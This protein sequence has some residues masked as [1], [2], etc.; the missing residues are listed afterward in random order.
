MGTLSL[1]PLFSDYVVFQRDKPIRIWGRSDAPITVNIGGH[2]ATVHPKNG[3]WLAE[4]PPLAAAEQVFCEIRSAGETLTLA[5][6]AVGEVWLAG[7]QSNMEWPLRYDADREG[8]IP[9]AKDLSF[10]FY[11]QPH[12]SYEG[13]DRDQD[14]STAG[15]WR[16]FDPENAPWF[17]AV[18]AYFG[19]DLRKAL[20]V[21]VGILG[22]NWGG[23]SAA[24]WVPP[25]ALET[26]S[27]RR[28][29]DDYQKDLDSLDLASYPEKYR[30]LFTQPVP[31]AF[32]AYQEINEK[33]MLG[34]ITPDEM[35]E[36]VKKLPPPPAMDDGD[37]MLM[38]KGPMSPTRPGSLYE[39]MLQK[40]APFPVRGVIWYQ[41]ET[42]HA[43]AEVYD[44]LLTAVVERWRALFQDD[45]PFFVVQLAPFGTV[46]IDDGFHYPAIRAAQAKVA[47]T[48][49]GVGLVSIMDAGAE[50]D[51]HPKHKKPVGERLALLARG[52]VY[53]ENLLCE[54][55]EP[56]EF[57]REAGG[58]T[59][60]FI[61]AEGGLVLR[62][63]ELEGLDCYDDAGALISGVAAQ[64]E[65][66][67]LVVTSP[68][69]IAKL[70]FAWRPY[71]QV[72]LYNAAGIAAAPFEY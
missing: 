68:R 42:D 17:S 22:C 46:W 10:R 54:F 64:V 23:T 39:C 40:V 50:K 2:T 34:E 63:A 38:F 24:A 9:F 1:A 30:A 8:I 25:E 51:I 12:A 16:P 36:R 49:P 29:L 37:A 61:H 15:F 67:R 71:V 60:S 18:G 19:V 43:Y 11:D 27:L 69:T 3:A 62:G 57:R 28:Y 20:G 52:R 53:G 70:R 45:F 35:M 47:K 6:A 65:G 32:Q 56:G 31:K 48:L 5:H 33:L 59:I 44:E 7:G 41:G 21:P 14:F 55:P 26:P 72:N 58:I 4:L 13:Q 66:S